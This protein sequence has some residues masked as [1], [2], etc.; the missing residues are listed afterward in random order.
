MQVGLLLCYS[1][2]GASL[3]CW[4]T[5]VGL[6]AGLG[7][8]YPAASLGV[9]FLVARGVTCVRSQPREILGW[10]CAEWLL[11]PAAAP[12]AVGGS[13]NAP[14]Q[15]WVFLHHRLGALEGDVDAGVARGIY[16]P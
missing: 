1:S 7:I 4:L 10:G 13:G 14:E 15:H 11:M 5:C 12:R 8:A 9:S 3:G 16:L 2:L 6:L